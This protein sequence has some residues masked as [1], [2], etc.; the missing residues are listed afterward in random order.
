[1]KNLILL[2]L[3]FVTNSYSLQTTSPA[4][5]TNGGTPT[6]IST[7]ANIH[8]ENWYNVR[9]DTDTPSSSTYTFTYDGLSITA[10]YL[11]SYSI[12]WNLASDPIVYADSFSIATI[13]S[14]IIKE[15]LYTYYV[16]T[17]SATASSGWYHNHFDVYKLTYECELAPEEPCPSGLDRI[18][19]ECPSC[20][21]A[22]LY[23]QTTV[24]GGSITCI[25]KATQDDR[26]NECLSYCGSS[27]KIKW[28]DY[29]P[30]TGN[31][32]CQC[33]TS[34]AS[35]PTQDYSDDIDNATDSSDSDSLLMEMF[36]DM[37]SNQSTLNDNISNL[38]LT[39]DETNSLIS[40]LNTDL[41]NKL[42]DN[43]IL[44][45]DTN[46]ILTTAVGFLDGIYDTLAGF[47]IDADAYMME[48]F[49][50]YDEFVTLMKSILQAINNFLNELTLAYEFIVGY[51]TGV[52]ES[53]AASEATDLESNNLL[54]EYVEDFEDS[55]NSLVSNIEQIKSIGTN[56]FDF[57]PSS[58]SISTCG[59]TIHGVDLL[60]SLFTLLAPFAV[61]ITLFVKV[62]FI[63][64]SIKI[65][66]FTIN[67]IAGA[68]L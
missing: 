24:L 40:G 41:S 64:T 9:W 32:T 3:L 27:D 34:N 21:D 35:I 7:E 63:W 38:G 60:G 19:G 42:N 8:T 57:N 14:D 50:F 55:Y 59:T 16:P 67:M 46:G 48:T 15:V 10:H 31:M 12:G 2:I 20:E 5:C 26:H 29:D 4:Q 51:V 47:V 61:F 62:A 13:G 11:S 6:I 54:S 65:Y 52:N 22:G 36:N 45:S 58:S 66:M 43:G 25:S 56:G 23:S 39:N 1:M 53:I 30:V 37:L 18:N 17:T 33:N 68:S 49:E 44:I 28:F